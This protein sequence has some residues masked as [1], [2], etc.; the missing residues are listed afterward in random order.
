[1]AADNEFVETCE[2]FGKYELLERIASG[3]MAEVFRG[4]SCSIGGF[5][6]LVALKRILPHLSTD[7]EFISLFIAEAKLAVALTHSNI[8]QVFDFGR[9]ES[10]YYLAMEFVDGKDLTQ[11]LIKQSRRKKQVPIEAACFILAAVLRG[12]EYAHTRRG[13]DGQELGIVHRDVSPHNI[14]VSFDGE[15]KLTDFG[16]AKARTHVSLSR[17][18]VV[19]GKFAYMSPEQ[20]RGQDVDARSDVYSAGITLYETLTGRR[21]FYSED[22]VQTLNKV[23]NPRIPTPSKYNPAIT[24]ELDA[25]VLKSLAVDPRERFAS[26]RDF[27]S[28]LQAVLSQLAPNYSTFE[29]AAFM[30]ELFGDEVP[31]SKFVMASLPPDPT[32]PHS[33]FTLPAHIAADAGRG[34]LADPVVGALAEKLSGEPNLW[35]VVEIGERLVKIDRLGEASRALRVAALKFAQNGLLVQSVALYVRMMELAAIADR[36]A[37]EMSQL[38]REVAALPKLVGKK[39][40][41][42]RELVGPLGND[43]LGELLNAVVAGSEPTASAGM[44]ASPLFSFL[45]PE[46]L[47]RLARMLKLKRVPPATVVINEGQKGQSLYIVAR[48]RVIIFC[49]NFQGE[50]VYLSSLADGDCFGEFSFFTAEPRTATVESVEE[51]LLFEIAQE[52]FDRVIEEF[53]GLTKALL[54]FYKERVVATLLA[55]SEVFGVLPPRVRSTLLE[56]LRLES[57]ERDEV[58]I[59]EGELSDGFY[60]IKSGE[61]EVFSER[62]GYV[63]LDKLGA[64][65]FFGEIA[66]ITAQP[67]T[68]T[69]RALGPIE[70]LRLQGKDLQELVFNNLE[71]MRVLERRIAQREAETVRR[72]SAGGLLT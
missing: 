16:I 55:K 34:G 45:Q 28:A 33:A 9:V 30:K 3:G 72:I 61:V 6:K 17:P 42:L 27:A 39:S 25:L 66:A 26:A 60:L 68:A 46:E 22:P 48:G 53:P 15:V 20:A 43:P 44:I 65:D 12:L 63:F 36:D 18:G 54:Q 40:H 19:L 5:R 47:A 21:L 2:L 7:A 62:Q 52:D 51:V 8:V 10:S 13:L 69:V 1:M 56:R 14:L 29:T 57:H 71:M 31:S 38:S 41:A 67:R 32:R 64:G 70:L 24:P 49:K 35:T 11:I 50:R 37:T 4:V 23:R 58:I 59:R